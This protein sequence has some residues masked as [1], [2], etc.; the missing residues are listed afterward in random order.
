LRRKKR[1]RP[2]GHNL[3]E[4]EEGKNKLVTFLAG[5]SGF[6]CFKK[7]KCKVE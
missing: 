1:R 5:E 2:R 6:F 3:E 4:E 7:L